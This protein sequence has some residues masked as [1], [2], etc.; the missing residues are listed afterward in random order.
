MQMGRVLFW[1]DEDEDAMYLGV[2]SAHAIN[3]TKA[4][5]A[6][7][8]RRPIGFVHFPDAEP[9]K[10]KRVK[11]RVPGRRVRKRR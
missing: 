7:A 8:K 4:R 6:A 9:V 3:D 11:R 1:D 10:A 2:G 5:G